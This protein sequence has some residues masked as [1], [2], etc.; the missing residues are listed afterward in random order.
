MAFA[1]DSIRAEA[2][3]KGG[4]VLQV[5]LTHRREPRHEW[6]W[7][8]LHVEVLV[9]S[10]KLLNWRSLLPALLWAGPVVL[11]LGCMVEHSRKH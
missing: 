8:R 9:P 6:M 10:L 5:V 2:S 3:P 7:K 11:N 4:C 1:S